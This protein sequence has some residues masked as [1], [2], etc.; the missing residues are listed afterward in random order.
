MSAPLASLS[1]LLFIPSF[2]LDSISLIHLCS[3]EQSILLYVALYKRSPFKRQSTLLPVFL[4]PFE[5]L[6]LS[7]Q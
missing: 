3:Y 2:Y 5:L 4:Q 7:G 1:L 6:G